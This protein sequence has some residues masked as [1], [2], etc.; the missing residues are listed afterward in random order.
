MDL[1]N[2]HFFDWFVGCYGLFLVQ[3]S[4]LDHEIEI[5]K[6]KDKEN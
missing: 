6:D 5:G 2:V 3:V 4:K 1:G